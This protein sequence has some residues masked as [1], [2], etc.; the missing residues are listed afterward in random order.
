M[1]LDPTQDPHDRWRAFI[2]RAFRLRRMYT[3]TGSLEE[4]S[5]LLV[6]FENGIGGSGVLDAFQ[7]WMSARHAENPS[8]AFSTLVVHEAFNT[9]GAD[10]VVERHRRGLADAKDTLTPE[11]N[12]IAVDLLAELLIAFLDARTID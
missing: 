4:M 6:G 9:H 11:E 3:A 7:K 10:G 1:H 2:T 8:L 5:A 12:R